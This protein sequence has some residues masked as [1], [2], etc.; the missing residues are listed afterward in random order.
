MRTPKAPIRP[1]EGPKRLF[2]TVEEARNTPPPDRPTWR[3]FRVGFPTGRVVYTWEIDTQWAISNAA[4]VSDYAAR[5]L[6]D[7][8]PDNPRNRPF[9]VTRPDGTTARVS[10]PGIPQAIGRVARDDGFTAEPA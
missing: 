6:G 8:A 5:P 1:G 7:A 10:A 2:T 9:E 4:R 3:I